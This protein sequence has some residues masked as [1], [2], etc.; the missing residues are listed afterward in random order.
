MRERLPAIGIAVVCLLVVTVPA[1][2]QLS[3]TCLRPFAIPDKWVENQT[4]PL[5]GSDT[6]DL[7][8]SNPDVYVPELGYNAPSDD[9]GL[10]NLPAGYFDNPPRLEMYL[11]LRFGYGGGTDFVNN[12]IACIGRPFAVGDVIPVESG[13]M[14]GPTKIAIEDLMAM[15]PTATWDPAAR[16]V[17][18]SAFARSPRVIQLPVFD[19]EEYARALQ[20]GIHEIRIVKIVGFFVDGRSP[21]ISIRGYLTAGARLT[22]SP[23][24][25]AVGDSATLTAR[26]AMPAG[27]VG[28]VPIEFKVLGQTVGMVSTT[29]SDE[30]VFMIVPV[31][32]IAPG[33]Y[34]GAIRARLGDGAGFL[35]AEESAADLT[36]LRAIPQ[37]TWPAPD[38]LIY[39]TP[40]GPSQLNASAPVPGQFVYTPPAGTV[41]HATGNQLL[42]VT[43]TPD[44]LQQYAE[45][46]TSV[47]IKALSAPLTL[48]VASS[49]KLYLDPLKAFALVADGFVNCDT[50]TSLSGSA[51]FQT[52]ATASSPIGAYAVYASGLSS[53]DY[54]VQYQPGTLN[55]VSRVAT[56][57]YPANGATGIDLTQPFTWTSVPGAQAYYLYVGT[58]AGGKDL[59]NTGEI[60]QTSYRVPQTVPGGTTVYARLWTKVGGTWGYIDSTFSAPIAT[61]IVARLSYPASGATIVDPAQPF[62]WNAIA[63]VQAYYLYVGSTPGAKDLVNTGE[64]LQTSY[65]LRTALPNNQTLCARLWTKVAGVWR[66]TDSTFSVTPLVATLTYPTN[67]A[68]N[69]D[70]T[71]PLRWTTIADAQVYYLYVGSTPGAKDLVNTGEIQQTSYLVRT[72]LPANQTLYARLWTKA[73]GIWRYRDSTFS[74][75]PAAH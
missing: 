49:S 28:G 57:L 47:V 40:L 73:G 64:T 62:T 27:P 9:G 70:V 41:L 4:P 56:L 2:A 19:P 42:T 18:N 60:Q 33:T 75:A 12:V 51:V 48:R 46:A 50:L 30:Q 38:I 63:H 72:A 21:F 58:S 11:P 39:G 6:F 17:V 36:I 55:V 25:A 7:L 59:V 69:I 66:F 37:V 3:T 74:A 8:A 34:P 10:L 53:P 68:T 45:V 67:G 32:T 26:I 29:S 20:N 1:Q 15:D 65:V 22:V 23:S 61:P 31:G 16:T 44:D 5:D 43:F 14:S 24:S 52:S 54:A 13:N 35:S 71:L